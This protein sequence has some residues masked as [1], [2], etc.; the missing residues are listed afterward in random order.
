MAR[1]IV[2]PK[3]FVAWL[4]PYLE[5]F[6]G[7]T[8]SRRSPSAP[9]WPAHC[10]QRAAHPGRRARLRGVSPGAQPQRLVGTGA[11]AHFGARPDRRLGSGRADH[12]RRRSHPGA[13]ARPLHR[14]GQ[15]VP[16]RGALVHG[17]DRHHPA[18]ADRHAVGR[19]ALRRAHLGATDADRAGAAPGARRRGGATAPPGRVSFCCACTAGFPTGCWSPSW[20]AS[21]PRWSCWTRS[22]RT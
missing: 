22:A 9:C 4:W 7:R 8:R 10:H 18:L 11:G 14:S 13:P 6:S 2:L 5:A 3:S 17:A 16:R 20:T 1:P 21:S 19:G 12:R 15:P